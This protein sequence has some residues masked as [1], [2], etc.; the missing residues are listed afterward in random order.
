MCKTDYG[1]GGD[2]KLSFETCR[3]S[4]TFR[5]DPRRI[6]PSKCEKR[7]CDSTDDQKVASRQHH[8]VF[9]VQVEWRYSLHFPGVSMWRGALRQ[10]TTGRR[11]G[12]N[13]GPQILS[14]THSG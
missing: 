1:G 2:Y 9:G 8:Q 6:R 13:T 11:N 4:N 7:V 5:Y 14:T 3:N 10:N 12:T